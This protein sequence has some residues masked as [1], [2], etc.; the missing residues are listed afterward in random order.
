MAGPDVFISYARADTEVARRLSRTLAARDMVAWWDDR[1]ELSAPWTDV[2]LNNLVSAASVL[3][4]WSCNSVDREWVLREAEDARSRGKLLQLRLDSTPLPEPFAS[5]Q[6]A[7]L[8]TWE[9][10]THPRGIRQIVNE[11]A[12]RAEKPLPFDEHQRVLQ[13]RLSSKK[14]HQFIASKKHRDGYFPKLDGTLYADIWESLIGQSPIKLYDELRPGSRHHL[15]EDRYYELI[16][17]LSDVAGEA[18]GTN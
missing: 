15:D 17:Y 9:E 12:T 8:P 5:L 2:L 6:A 7:S 10:N 18:A 13:L 4:L 11:I 14:V 16:E 3:V 1:I